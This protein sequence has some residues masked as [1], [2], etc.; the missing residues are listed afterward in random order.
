MPIAQD[1]ICGLGLRQHLKTFIKP[2]GVREVRYCWQHIF[3]LKQ[4]LLWIQTQAN[5]FPFIQITNAEKHT[6]GQVIGKQLLA[7]N[8]IYS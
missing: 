1:L 8:I 6:V 3:G 5:P 4:N 7:H 2:K